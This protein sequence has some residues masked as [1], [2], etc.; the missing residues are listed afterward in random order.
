[1]RFDSEVVL[2]GTGVAPLVAAARL[3]AAGRRV[4]VLNPEADFFLEDSE[5]PLEPRSSWEKIGWSQP[6]KALEF[7]RPDYPGAIEL[8][9]KPQRSEGAGRDWSDRAAP[10]VRARSRIW[11]SSPGWDSRVERDDFF[12]Q[13]LDHG[14]KPQALDAEA[15]L[16]R[17]P[18]TSP[19]SGGGDASA[20]HGV[21]LPRLVDIDLNRYRHGLLEFLK[22]RLGEEGLRCGVSPM[23]L[24][25]EGL[26]FHQ[27]GKS[28]TVRVSDRLVVFWTPR[29]GPWIAAQAKRLEAKLPQPLGVRLWEQWIL[30]SRQ[31]LDPSVV[32]VLGNL[33][34]WGEVE[35][36]PESEGTELLSILRPADELAQGTLGAGLASSAS[37]RDL[38]RFCSEFLCWDGFSVRAY[39]PRWVMEWAG[40]SPPWVNLPQPGHGFEVVAGADGALLSVVERA[41]RVA[42]RIIE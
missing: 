37:I 13:A 23:E 4:V 9:P 6:E 28:R 39:R 40:D 26:R 41:R 35:G 7:L 38:S 30:R 24:F 1:M 42:G 10:H 22:E 32:G 27:N 3:T 36:A 19:R 12:I 11:L 5:L 33:C 20:W 17:F 18:G 34:V 16:A 29:L 2:V 14:H 31:K 8:W 15:A 25:P 21:Q